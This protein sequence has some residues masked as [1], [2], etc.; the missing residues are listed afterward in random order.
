[1]KGAEESQN[2]REIIEEDSKIVKREGRQR[3]REREREGQSKE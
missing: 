3:E 1:M 2:R